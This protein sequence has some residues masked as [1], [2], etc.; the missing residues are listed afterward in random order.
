MESFGICLTSSLADSVDNE[1]LLK[2]LTLFEYYDEVGLKYLSIEPT[3]GHMPI[4]EN[5]II[6]DTATLDLLD[7]PH[8]IGEEI[9]LTLT[10]QIGR[11]SCRERVF[12][13][14]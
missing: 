10:V 4:E 12:Q 14:V 13:R 2:R 6:T 11:A 8:E 1:A 3:S 9:T 7:V 5:E